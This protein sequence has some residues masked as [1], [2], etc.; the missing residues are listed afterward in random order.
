M[1]KIVV[2]L[3]SLLLLASCQK[4]SEPMTLKIGV[5]PAVDAAPIYYA[6]EKGYFTDKNLT[7]EISLFTNGIDRQSALQ[8]NEVDGT[9]TDL[10]AVMSNVSNG[11]PIK[12]TSITNGSFPIITRADFDPSQKEI[13]VAMMEVSITNYLADE[14]L[15]DYTVNKVFIN[16]IPARIEMLKSGDVDMAVL[17]EPVASQAESAGLKRLDVG[18]TLSP[19][20]I[21]FTQT[22][23]DNKDKEIKI[24]YEAYNK[25]VDEIAKSQDDAKALLITN[26]KTPE[27]VAKLMVLPTYDK[28]A[29]PSVDQVSKISEWVK[30]NLPPMSEVS[31]DQLIEK[32][33]AK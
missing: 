7:V 4:N 22:A 1:K 6:L 25:A 11:F 13:K 24:F 31:Y 28:A 12:A 2:L 10:I 5:M 32:K 15:S 30:N 9:I 23:L 29:L 26:L 33:Y 3:L 18:S 16:E 14:M 20:C 8:S 21:A 19:D 27:G 17:P